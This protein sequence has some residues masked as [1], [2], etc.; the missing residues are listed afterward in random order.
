MFGRNARDL[1]GR[2]V[3]HGELPIPDEAAVGDLGGIQFL[4]HHRLHRV[5]PQPDNRTSLDLRGSRVRRIRLHGSPFGSTLA[6]TT[7]VR[8]ATTS[9]QAVNGAWNLARSEPPDHG[10]SGRAGAPAVPQAPEFPG[11]MTA[12]SRSRL[13]AGHRAFES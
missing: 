2:G 8:S 6:R 10:S 5:A 12:S 7:E 11:A 4:A 9:C 3:H 1:P 13:A